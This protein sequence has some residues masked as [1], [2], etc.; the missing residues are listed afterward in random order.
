[1]LTLVDKALLVKF[2]YLKEES[3]AEALRKF[4]IEKKMKNGSGP[5]IFARL[6]DTSL[7]LDRSEA[8]P[9]KNFH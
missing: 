5:I 2:Y 4:R 8:V 1:M 7:Y 3:A 9:E 6:I